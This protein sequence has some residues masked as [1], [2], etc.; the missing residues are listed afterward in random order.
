MLT[1]TDVFHFLTHEL[2]RLSAW[3]LTRALVS[4]SPLDRSLFWHVTLR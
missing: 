3:R 4:T 2:P 1:L